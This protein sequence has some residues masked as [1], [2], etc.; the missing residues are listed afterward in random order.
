MLEQLSRCT[1][2]PSREECEARTREVVTI[3]LPPERAQDNQRSDSGASF[4]PCSSLSNAAR[5]S[6]HHTRILLLPL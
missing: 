1:S 5:P 6:P 2:C 3:W 4:F